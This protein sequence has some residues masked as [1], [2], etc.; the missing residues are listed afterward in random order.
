MILSIK[1]VLSTR[2]EQSFYLFLLLLVLPFSP[3]LCLLVTEHDGFE[4][5]H[6]GRMVLILYAIVYSNEMKVFGRPDNEIEEEE[7]QKKKRDGML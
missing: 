4:C 2:I 5:G 7:K 3:I 6:N 1:L